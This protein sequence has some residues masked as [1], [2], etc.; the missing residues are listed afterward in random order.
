M[1]HLFVRMQALKQKKLFILDYHDVFIP[2][3]AKVRK[4]KGRTL[5]GSRT[6]FFLNPDGTLR[7]LAIELSRPPI[8]NEPQWKDVFTPCW[9]AYG[10]WLWRIAKAHV[11]AHDSGHHQLITHWYVIDDIILNFTCTR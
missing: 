1:Y 6:L 10:L 8:D 2:Y 5:Y 11:L 4:L 3:V 9:D 7:P